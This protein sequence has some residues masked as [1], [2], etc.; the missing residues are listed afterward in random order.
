MAGP[1]GLRRR[2]PRELGRRP[3]NASLGQD[4]AD[5]LAAKHRFL[6]S[7]ALSPIYLLELASQQAQWLSA[8]Q[9]TTATNIANANTP[10][11]VSMDV[12][13]FSDVLD[14]TQITMV[15]TNS[16]DILPEGNDF[17]ATRPATTDSW[18]TTYSGNSVSLEQEM[19]K[20]GE[21][22]RSFTLNANI[23]RAFHQMLMLSVK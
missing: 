5:N 22:N 8:R 12:Q 20:E 14:K 13:P 18:E 10:G 23:K 6:R 19:M 16:A 7:S 21:I 1:G 3:I 11:F 2:T 15:A 4:F 9:R 17:T